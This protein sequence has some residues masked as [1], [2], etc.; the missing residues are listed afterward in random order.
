MKKEITIE[1]A[2]NLIR[3]CTGVLLEGRYI[4]PHIFEIEGDYSN[5]WMTLQW[6]EVY[7]GEEIDV[8]V[9]FKEGDNQKVEF[10]G[11]ILVL[12]NSDGEEEELTLLQ[13]WIPE[14]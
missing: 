7:C 13:E 3:Q 5:E 11:S 8:V 6:E 9:G 4:E 2:Y 14:V 10:D 12:V 1:S